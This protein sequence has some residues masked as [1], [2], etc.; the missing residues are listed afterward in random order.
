M[1]PGYSVELNETYLSVLDERELGPR[2]STDAFASPARL[3]LEFGAAVEVRSQRRFRPEAVGVSLDAVEIH[4]YALKNAERFGLTKDMVKEIERKRRAAYSE[5]PDDYQ[6]RVDVG[7]YDLKSG[8]YSE[9]P[10]E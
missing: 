10:V 7:D 8:E 9:L 2:I 4:D 5:L 1:P 6:R 3:A